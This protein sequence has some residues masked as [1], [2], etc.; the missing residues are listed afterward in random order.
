MFIFAVVFVFDKLTAWHLEVDV[1]L[2]PAKRLER[3][4]CEDN[5]GREIIRC[6]VEFLGGVVVSKVRRK[7]YRSSASLRSTLSD[8]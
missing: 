6:E 4:M 8:C 2:L 1:Q 3:L 5:F 7:V